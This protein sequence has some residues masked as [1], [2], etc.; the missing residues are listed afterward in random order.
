MSER[1]VFSEQE[2]TDIIRA[3]VELQERLK[4][5][6]D[7]T[8]GLTREELMRMAA[9][10]GLSEEAM[11]Q[12]IAAR[13]QI[14]PADKV[15]FW[16]QQFSRVID[17]ELKPEDFDLVGG[18]ITVTG[19]KSGTLK[20]I[21]RTLSGTVSGGISYATLDV[22]SRNGRTRIA[23][24]SHPLIAFIFTAYPAIALGSIL[25]LSLASGGN[26]FLG[27][28]AALAAA[29]AGWFGL[30]LTLPLAHRRMKELADELKR[31]IE[32]ELPEEP[33]RPSPSVE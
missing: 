19:N 21:G 20:Q 30:N 4:S 32:E 2:A 10:M 26:P 1:E 27:G 28:L 15:G 7:Y 18:T 24:K 22:T 6:D 25:G 29:G 5:G 12:A 31:R 13:G 33:D 3:A 11:R 8:P 16:T 17:R 14:Q 9:E 23:L